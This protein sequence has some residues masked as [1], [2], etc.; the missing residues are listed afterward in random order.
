[1]TPIDPIALAT[2]I[3]GILDDLRIRYVI[4]GSVAAS[5]YGEPRST[6][7]LDMMIDAD[8]EKVEALVARLRRDFYVNRDDAVEAAR[9]HSSFSA[10]EVATS[11]KVD[12]FLAEK[13]SFAQEQMARRR[14][15][16]IASVAPLHF[17]APED[18]I[19]RKLMWYRAGGE[20]SQRQWRDVAGIMRT[21]G[22][23]IDFDYL[24]EAAAKVGVT[25]L[26]LRLEKEEHA[27]PA[28]E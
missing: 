6:L 3:A 2:V 19:I 7:D 9:L 28:Q 1:L 13:D 27:Q 23:Q 4:G 8:E 22:E 12:F 10:V 11:M 20:Q 16:R 17:Y 26:L 24:R 15:V 21:S 18:L 14:P 5:I 25:D